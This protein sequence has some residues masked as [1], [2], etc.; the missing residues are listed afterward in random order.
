[1]KKFGENLLGFLPWLMATLIIGSIVHI[2]SILA[3]PRLAPLSSFARIAA[4]TPLHG[5]VVLPRTIPQRGFA[6]FEDPAMALGACLFDLEEGALRLRG[7]LAPD[8]L[9]LF[10]FHGRDG[11]AFYSMT[12]RGAARGKLDVL[13]LTQPQLDEVEANDDEDALPQDLRI[14]APD[15][16]GFVLL[17]A[18]AERPGDLADAEARI[19]AITCVPEREPQS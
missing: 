15:R 18:L 9:M 1:M 16:E 6:P 3:M 12:D 11:R 13:I 19:A 2:V 4:L 10:S 14:V 17:R 7:T 8:D 5:M